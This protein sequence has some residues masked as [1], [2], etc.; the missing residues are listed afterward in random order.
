VGIDGKYGRVT[1]ER[2]TIGA[3]EPVIVFRAQDKLLPDLLEMYGILCKHAGSPGR[4]LDLIDEALQTV[5][6]WQAGNY[7]QVP[8]S[9]P[10]E[11]EK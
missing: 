8:Q 11:E 7:T 9:K 4:H 1:T 2:G 6:S 10:A 3:D 5:R